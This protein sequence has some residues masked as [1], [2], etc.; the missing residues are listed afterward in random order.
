M[1]ERGKE[2]LKRR[3]YGEAEDLKRRIKEKQT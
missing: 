2:G 1:V 3:E